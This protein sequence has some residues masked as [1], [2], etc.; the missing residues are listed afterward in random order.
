MAQDWP[1]IPNHCASGHC[2][3]CTERRAR[4]RAAMLRDLIAAAKPSTTFDYWNRKIEPRRE[5]PRVHAT[6]YPSQVPKQVYY[7]KDKTSRNPK[8]RPTPK[9][10]RS[11]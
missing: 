4:R 3:W 6:P 8:H 7:L 2:N 10:W 1:D 5:E 9:H 11:A